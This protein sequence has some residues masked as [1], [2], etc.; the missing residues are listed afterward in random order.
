[1]NEKQVAQ[2]LL[3]LA[4][5]IISRDRKITKSTK[6]GINK[7]GDVYEVVFDDKREMLVLVDSI[8]RNVSV[9][10]DGA[11]FYPT[12]VSLSNQV[13]KWR[14]KLGQA[15]IDQDQSR[16]RKLEKKLEKAVHGW[17]RSPGVARDLSY[18]M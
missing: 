7:D 10:L 17:F 9:S 2:E 16:I 6:V 14:D 15:Y 4:K 18:E 5:K 12:S 11:R 13:E 8:A 1:M 3:K